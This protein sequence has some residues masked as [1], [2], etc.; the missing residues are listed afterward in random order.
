M[1]NFERYPV[2]FKIKNLSSLKR[3]KEKNYELQN[4]RIN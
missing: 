4:N 2:G 3:K 1:K